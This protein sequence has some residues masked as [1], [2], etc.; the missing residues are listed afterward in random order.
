MGHLANKLPYE[1]T[2]IDAYRTKA[3]IDGMLHEFRMVDRDTN[4][5]MAKITAVRWTDVPPN[6]PMLEFMME[7]VSPE[8]VKKGVA[9][10]LQ[11]PLFYRR[12]KRG[13][14]VVNEPQPNQSMRIL[15]WYLK[16]KLEAILY[17]MNDA[18]KEFLSEVLISLPN[19]KQTT[20]G[21]HIIDQVRDSKIPA[22]PSPVREVT[23]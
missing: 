7:Y 9:I 16:S 19:G 1:G 14:Q 8:G 4:T 10:K 20:V 13:G 2:T 3:E 21:E 15:Y 12:V 5:E 18:T 17:G 6:M 11:P 22:L 23:A